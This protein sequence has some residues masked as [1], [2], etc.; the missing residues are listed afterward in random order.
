VDIAVDDEGNCIASL[1][2]RT[3]APIGISHV[4]TLASVCAMHRNQ[5]EACGSERARQF[6]RVERAMSHRAASSS[7]RPL[8]TADIVARS[9]ISAWSRSRIKAEP[10]WPPV[11]MARSS[12]V[13]V[14]NFR[15]WAAAIR[16]PRNPL[17]FQSPRAEPNA[18]IPVDSP[19]QARDIGRPGTRSS[20]AVISETTNPAPSAAVKRRKAGH[21]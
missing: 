12:H 18:D 5:L 9:V 8:S 1:T 13:D 17:W 21:R 3:A 10:D 20:L 11:T 6:R 4:E 15:A 7:H 2:A 16:R 19:S 14:D